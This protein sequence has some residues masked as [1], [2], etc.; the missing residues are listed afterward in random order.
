M[1]DAVLSLHTNPFA[2]GI[3]KF[4]QALA[5]RLGVPCDA[6]DAL[7]AHKYRY[8]LVS[9]KWAELQSTA[10]CRRFPTG[11]FALLWH[12]AGDP[13]LTTRA[14]EV[15]YATEMGCPSTI[16]GDPTR[17]T[18]DVLCFGMAHK[19]QAPHFERLRDLLAR[20]DPNYTVS[21]STACLLYTSPSPRDA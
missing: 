9:V 10:W 12:D 4:N 8:P 2:C 6:L 3:A 16:E 11:R 19:F 21:L 18:L 5:Q 13:A 15:H 14:A 20:T 17:G 7:Q 1:I